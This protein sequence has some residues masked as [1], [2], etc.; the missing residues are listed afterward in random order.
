FHHDGP[1]G[2]VCFDPVHQ[3]ASFRSLFTTAEGWG[4]FSQERSG[5]R[6]RNA[7]RLDYGKLRLAE[8][9]LGIR[10][11]PDKVTLVLGSR[12]LDATPHVDGGTL[13]LVLSREVLL[14]EGQSLSVE[15][16]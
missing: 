10:S 1:A 8:L 13:R 2:L 11:K 3:P 16:T 4:S 14:S 7:L 9:R 12:K 15:L 6:Q 5:K